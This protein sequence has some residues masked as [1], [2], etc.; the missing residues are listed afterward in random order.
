[1]YS[2]WNFMLLLRWLDSS[3]DLMISVLVYAKFMQAR[4]R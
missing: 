3:L 1:M 4:K 2:Q